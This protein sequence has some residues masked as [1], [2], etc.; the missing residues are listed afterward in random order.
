MYLIKTLLCTA[1]L[2]SIASTVL[3]APIVLGDA[4]EDLALRTDV[5]TSRNIYAR[6]S[7]DALMGMAEPLLVREQ[8]S[9]LPHPKSKYCKIRQWKKGCGIVKRSEYSEDEF[10]SLAARARTPAHAPTITSD[11][12][13]KLEKAWS[14]THNIS[15]NKDLLAAVTRH[16]GLSAAQVKDWFHTR[17]R[18]AMKLKYADSPHPLMPKLP[19]GPVPPKKEPSIPVRIRAEDEE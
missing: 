8:S 14:V 19:T 13:T 10:T 2:A 15:P 7:D 9:D 11:Q 1:A 5:Q 16:T 17:R 18:Q 4:T 3:C 6:T 12:T